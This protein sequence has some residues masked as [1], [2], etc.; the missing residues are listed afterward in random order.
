MTLWVT[1]IPAQ[2]QDRTTSSK[3]GGSD[4]SNWRGASGTPEESDPVAFRSSAA[5][6]RGGNLRITPGRLLGGACGT[7]LGFAHHRGGLEHSHV[8]WATRF[9]AV[10]LTHTCCGEV[11]R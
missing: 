6:R 1:T 4:D 5:D 10:S 7:F 9:V 8:G 3:G 11:S 2:E